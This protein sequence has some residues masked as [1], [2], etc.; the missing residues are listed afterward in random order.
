MTQV[1]AAYKEFTLG[2]RI[3]ISSRGRGGLKIFHKDGNKKIILVVILR[4][5][6]F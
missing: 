1:Y 4:Q 2:L 5:N 3:K 6:R